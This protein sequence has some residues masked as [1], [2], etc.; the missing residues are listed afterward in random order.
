MANDLPIV[1]LAPVD[2]SAV[3]APAAR[4]GDAQIRQSKRTFDEI[5]TFPGS[6]KSAQATDALDKN[7]SVHT[8]IWDIL[9]G[10]Y[11]LPDSWPTRY[12]LNGGGRL[13][14]GWFTQLIY[15]LSRRWRGR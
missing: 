15:P 7:F 12:G 11:Y 10:T 6:R 8:P 14:R 9:F 4:S 1:P 3:R 2:L 13:P 5:F